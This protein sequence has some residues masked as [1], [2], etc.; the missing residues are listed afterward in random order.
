MHCPSCGYD[1]SK[2]VD[3]RSS[4]DGESIRRRRECLKCGHRFTTY[5][6]IN[7]NPL[8]VIK[9]DGSSEVYDRNKLLRGLVTACA[10]RP[11]SN[12]DINNLIDGIEVELHN[13]PKH[14]VHSKEIGEMALE[15]LADLDEVAY[16]RF[17]S[18]YKDFQ[19]IGEFSEALKGLH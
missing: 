12:K 9:R 13:V 11:V 17:A 16:I 18:V 10:R 5:E 6:R 8:I 15:R 4:D 19:D 2:V 7:D 1:D 14:E 3:S